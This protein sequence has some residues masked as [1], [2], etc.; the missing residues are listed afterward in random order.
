[1]T[2]KS[3]F[4]LIGIVVLILFGG[5]LIAGYTIWGVADGEKRDFPALL[6]EAA[7]YVASLETRQSELET[8]LA[9]KTQP[10]PA[11]GDAETATEAAP[12]EAPAQATPSEAPAEEAGDE[13]TQSLE[14]RL[15]ALQEENAALQTALSSDKSVAEKNLEL[16]DRIQ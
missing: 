7:Q 15:A 16:T 8:Q 10:A 11:T 2:N 1:M 4:I 13:R 12:S 5:G 9:A 3:K 14:M 6:R